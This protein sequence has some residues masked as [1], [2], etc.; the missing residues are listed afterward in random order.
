[1]A[2]NVG[3]DPEYFEEYHVV[4]NTDSELKLSLLDTTVFLYRSY[5]D[6]IVVPAKDTTTIL[7]AN[8]LGT[9]SE[10][11]IVE[12]L[13][14]SLYGDSIMFSFFDGDTLKYTSIDTL[15]GPY[16]FENSMYNVIEYRPGYSCLTYIVNDSVK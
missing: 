14:S 16:N 5:R 11:Q 10:M 15:E 4:N 1:V 8:N 9:T 7:I 6:G 2:V 12:H 13:K 3:C